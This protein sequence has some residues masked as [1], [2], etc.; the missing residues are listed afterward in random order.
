MNGFALDFQK[1]SSDC[2]VKN[3]FEKYWDPEV[4]NNVMNKK[5]M[6]GDV[7]SMVGR[8]IYLRNRTNQI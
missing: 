7:A 2:S 6:L 3:G 8:N 4:Y 1:I 5:K